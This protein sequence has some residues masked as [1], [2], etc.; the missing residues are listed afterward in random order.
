M[1]LF[2]SFIGTRVTLLVASLAVAACHDTTSPPTPSQIVGVPS[3]SVTGQAGTTVPVTVRV[4]SSNGQGLAGQIVTFTPTTGTVNPTTATTDANGQAQTN[5]T[6]GTAVGTQTL[7]AAV[8]SLT[9]LTISAVVS[10]G[11]P[12]HIDITAGNTQTG[13]VGSTVATRP[14]VKVTDAGGNPVPGASVVFSVTGG[15]GTLTGG[16]TTTDAQGIA[17]VGSFQ[18]GSTAGTNTVT[19]QV[20][21]PTLTTPLVATFTA[22]GTAGAAARVAATQGNNV[23]GAVGS[24]LSGTSLPAVLV[25]DANNNPVAGATVTFTATTGGGTVTGGTQTTNAQGVATIGGFTLGTAVGPNIVTANVAGVGSTTFTITGQPGAPSQVQIVSG[26]NQSVAAGALLP[27]APSVVVRDRF[28]NPVPGVTVTFAATS[29]NGAV[30]GATQTTNS[31][32]VAAAGSFQLG[33][34]PGA[35]TFEARVAGLTPAVFTETGLAGPPATISKVTA[36][37]V[38]VTAFQTSSPFTVLVRDAAGF[39]VSGATVTFAV[40]SAKAGT[41]SAASV[42][43]DAQG[44]ASATLAAG[45][46]VDT[47]TSL[48]ERVTEGIGDLVHKVI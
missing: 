31:S 46:V 5:W 26:N 44:Q 9:P 38:V 8:G 22:T 48:G 45:A 39:P 37:T 32:G 25:T 7:N 42:T 30:Q 19:A 33:A 16:V 2:R 47:A 3:Q 13:A 4:T 28:G 21:D 40:D 43:T 36:D 1:R 24:A 29:G 11:K 12:A 20:V 18:L 27:A 34:T 6:L 14:S 23:N 10:A 15:G 41:L 17:T 35:N